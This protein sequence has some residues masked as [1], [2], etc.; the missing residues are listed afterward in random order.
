M[1]LFGSTRYPKTP[2]FCHVKNIERENKQ[3]NKVR[4]TRDLMEL[5]II[6]NPNLQGDQL[7][8]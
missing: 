5:A 3:R 2:V 8:N 6:I 4:L 7:H 1:L